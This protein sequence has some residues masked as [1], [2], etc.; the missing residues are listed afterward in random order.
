MQESNRYPRPPLALIVTGEEW[1]SLSVETLFS[2]RGY[3]VLRA[4]TGVQALE[5]IRQTPPDLVVIAKDLRDMRGVD[6]CRV[7]HAQSL[8]NKVMPVM[9]IAPSPWTREERLEA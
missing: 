9:L 5:R 8:L 2:P 4:F 6:L 7:G 1:L 3:A